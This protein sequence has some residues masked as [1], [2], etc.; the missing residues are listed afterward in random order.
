MK[1]LYFIFSL[2]FISGFIFA[3]E[4]KVEVKEPVVKFSGH[5]NYEAYYDTYE[6]VTTREGN[7]YLY[8]VRQVLNND[9]EDIKAYSSLN[10]LS[11][12]SRLRAKINGPEAF[13]AKVNG[14]V[15]VD[16]LGNTTDLVQM[17]RIRHMFMSLNWKKSQLIFGQTWHPIF[18]TECFPQVISMGAALL[19]NPLNR[20]PQIKF[21][22][23]LTENLQIVGAALSHLDH[24]SVGP[25]TAQKNAG[26][27]DFHGQLKFKSGSLNTGL[28]AGYKVLK[29]RT[30]LS[31]NT[32][33]EEK[34]GSYDVAAFAKIKSND[35]TF[36]IYGVYG[37]NLSSFVMI[38]GYGAA[39]DPNAVA[40]YSYSNINTMAIW[41]E[42][43]YQINPIGLGF[44][45]GYSA[46]LGTNTENFYYAKSYSR[47]GNLQGENIDNI[48]RVSP[49]ITY[50]S[51][52]VMLGLEYM[53]TTATYM[54]LTDDK[55]EA[56]K[57][58]NNNDIIDDAVVNH[59]IYFSA[60][61]SF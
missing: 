34:I 2:V 45:A 59:R 55:F 53:M 24:A 39:E 11:A 23:H 37:Q 35:L 6:S 54:T 29:P 44:F 4:A 22:Y 61:Y 60:K 42:L 46:N 52:K 56:A 17:P 19:F 5:I 36:K 40:D 12:Q 1:K 10:M 27:P 9:N 7:I 8:P 58:V 50:T 38:G 43:I 57:D 26:I 32:I 25:A 3:Q 15:E 33:T 49:R 21:T 31:D 51:G 20:A 48:F 14:M 41:S 13:N 28:V 18:V 16:F 47:G 30:V